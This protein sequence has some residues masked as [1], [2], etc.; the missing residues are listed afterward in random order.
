M[1]AL[2]FETSVNLTSA[3]PGSRRI[4]N[5]RIAFTFGPWSSTS[6]VRSLVFTVDLSPIKQY[7]STRRFSTNLNSSSHHESPSLVSRDRVVTLTGID[8]PFTSVT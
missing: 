6:V 4:G 5:T 7:R 3:R 8:C 1:L 2:S